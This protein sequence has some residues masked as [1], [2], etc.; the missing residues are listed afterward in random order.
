MRTAKAY[1]RRFRLPSTGRKNLLG[2]VRSEA[3]N[4]D[5]DTWGIDRKTVV[6]A[7]P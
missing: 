5:F 1:Y 7:V 3:D 6:E 2:A 4:L